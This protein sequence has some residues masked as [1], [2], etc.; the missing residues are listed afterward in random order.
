MKI[1]GLH[2]WQ[3]SHTLTCGERLLIVTKHKISTV[4]ERKARTFLTRTYKYNDFRITNIHYEGVI[5]A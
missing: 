2:L 4:A 3:V 5:D 1:P